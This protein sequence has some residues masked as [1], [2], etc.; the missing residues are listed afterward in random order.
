VRWG[1]KATDLYEVAELPK[2]NITAATFKTVLMLS[3]GSAFATA[4]VA[5]SAQGPAQAAFSGNNG[6][7]VY[8]Q[9]SRGDLYTVL[10][11]GTA[12]KRVTNNKVAEDPSWSTNGKIAFALY[13]RRRAPE[14]YVKYKDR[15]RRL[16][17]NS[18][19]DLDPAW[20]PDGSKLAFESDSEVWTAEADGSGSE[21]RLTD[22]W[23]TEG[24]IASAPDWSPDGS[25]IIFT[26]TE[27][28]C[29]FLNDIWVVNADGTDLK[30][31]TD[32]SGG[33]GEDHPVWSP[34]GRQIAYVRVTSRS[35]RASIWKMNAHGTNRRRIPNT[36]E[37]ETPDWRALPVTSP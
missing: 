12:P 13:L 1:R 23:A 18:S 15:L 26:A 16:T 6:R 30:N 11:N 24:K 28:G 17:S 35:G 27:P 10:P 2:F 31:L 19:Y 20:S 3:M 37:G 5:M 33:V 32:T 7:L 14:I 36:Y 22:L 4:V 29:C 9:Y 8:S 25:K 21:T 34:D